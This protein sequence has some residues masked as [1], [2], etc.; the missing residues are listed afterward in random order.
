MIQVVVA[1]LL[2]MFHIANVPFGSAFTFR[3]DQPERSETCSSLDKHASLLN[4]VELDDVISDLFNSAPAASTS[5]STSSPPRLLWSSRC[6][7]WPGK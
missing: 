5:G 3:Q 6:L 1:M 4:H 2:L 7:A